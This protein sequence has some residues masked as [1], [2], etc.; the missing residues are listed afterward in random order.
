MMFDYKIC[1]MRYALCWML[2]LVVTKGQAEEQFWDV[3]YV[4]TP[5]V[6][7]LE[8]YK[9]ITDREVEIAEGVGTFTKI[10][11][12]SDE[13]LSG[14]SLIL[15]IEAL[16]RAQNISLTNVGADRV[17]ADWIVPPKAEPKEEPA[18]PAAGSVREKYV[19]RRA[20][21][22]AKK[23][24]VKPKVEGEELKRYLETYGLT[25]LDNGVVLRPVSNGKVKVFVLA[26]QSNMQG[27]G[28]VDLDHPE[29]YNGGK[30]T[31]NQVMKANPERYSHLKDA[32]GNWVER[33]DVFVRYQTKQKL[34]RGKCTIGFTGYAGPHHIGPE[35]QFGHVVGDETDEP[36][37]LIKTAWGGKSLHKDFRP[38]LAGGETGAYYEQMI[39]EI[40]LGMNRASEEFPPL[41]G[42]D[43]E[44]S[45]FVWFQGWNDMGDKAARDAYEENLACLIGDVRKEFEV[46]DLP[47]VIGELGNGGRDA[48]GSMVEIRDAQAAVAHRAGFAGTVAFVKTAEFARPKEASPNVGHGHHWFGNAESYFLI[49]DALGKAM[50][51]LIED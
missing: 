51:E 40:H 2:L 37:L 8:L 16:L 3:T 23:S 12:I 50:L 6:A 32:E 29:Y 48:S 49:G 45:G 41:R 44:L 14:S 4:D 10:N 15:K 7:V 42:R 22:M 31:L 21:M 19:K 35:L 17:I 11:F 43:L 13:K 33:D 26:G 30:G 38:P 5:V 28:V 46:E 24:Q 20:E 27:Q 9:R 1:W 47:V 36:V 18:P 25:V 34:L 39:E